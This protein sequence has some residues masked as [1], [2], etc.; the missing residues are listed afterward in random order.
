MMLDVYML[1]RVGKDRRGHTFEKFTTQ[2]PR[3]SMAS[4]IEHVLS[5]DL[6]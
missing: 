5:L 2:E 6:T 4:I 1:A 3:F